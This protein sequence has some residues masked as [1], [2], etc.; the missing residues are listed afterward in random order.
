MAPKKG[1]YPRHRL[2]AHLSKSLIAGYSP[3]SASSKKTSSAF[4][5]PFKSLFSSH[6]GIY[7]KWAVNFQTIAWLKGGSP[8]DNAAPN[9]QP[10]LIFIRNLKD[11]EMVMQLRVQF[12]TLNGV[13][14]RAAFRQG[15][16][17]VNQLP[18][19]GTEKALN[20]HHALS[21]P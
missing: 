7:Q 9:S 17:Q 10:A 20:L 6:F 5:L 13:K 19:C 16:A 8:L 1:L 21:D 11:F 18:G 15:Q 14:Y 12:Q 4:T 3:N 2:G